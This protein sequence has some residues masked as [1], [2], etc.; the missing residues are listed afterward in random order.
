MSARTDLQNREGQNEFNVRWNDATREAGRFTA[1]LRV[2]NESRSLPWVLPGLFRVADHVIIVDNDSDDGTPEVAKQVAQEHGAA[3]RLDVYDYPFSV[4]RCGPEHLAVP[5]E[6]VHSLTYF[7][8]WSFS[9]V[10]TSYCLKWD[11]DMV[12]TIDGEAYLKQ[13]RWQLEGV[14]TIVQIPRYGVYIESE[15]VA[16]LDT[17]H[18]NLE[19]WAWPNK[20]AYH[21]GKAFEW[22]ILVR[23]QGTP[24]IILPRWSLFE[25]KWL[26]MDEF[27]N[28]GNT[29]FVSKVRTGRKNREWAVFQ[30]VQT[31][32]MPEGVF[33]IEADGDQHVIEVLRQPETVRYVLESQHQM[34]DS[35]VYIP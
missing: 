33:R 3:E 23:P 29:D 8:N 31:G 35:S 7:Y 27:T 22:E 12:L 1:V 21:F 14:D 11:G 5:A 25:L 4:A 20:P 6:S 2:K 34:E 18:V 32:E 24:V 30:A 16:Y 13:L 9:H 15:K 28:W 10:K 26:D 19:P 17:A